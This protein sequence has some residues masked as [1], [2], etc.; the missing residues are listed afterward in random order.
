MAF[1]SMIIEFA[2]ETKTPGYERNVNLG[3]HIVKWA[4]FLRLSESC[5]IPVKLCTDVS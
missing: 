2:C 1:E 3:G 5:D 4:D